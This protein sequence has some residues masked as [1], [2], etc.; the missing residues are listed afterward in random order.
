MKV[1]IKHI[2]ILSA[3]KLGAVFSALV[4]MVSFLPFTLIQA[5]V[6]G[7]GVFAGSGASSSEINPGLMT[8]LGLV[9][10]CVGVGVGAFL[11][12]L[13]GG[14]GAAI[15]AFVY[16]LVSGWIGGV[17]VDLETVAGTV[18]IERKKRQSPRSRPTDNDE[19]GIEA[20]EL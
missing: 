16:N 10:I 15:S 18:S 13:L 2:D 1:R 17:E 7:A 20:F 4:F 14:I 3:F 8:G 6:L 5:L 9:G 19:E 11:Y 12:A